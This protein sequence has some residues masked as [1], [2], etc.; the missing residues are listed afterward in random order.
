MRRLSL[1]GIIYP[2]PAWLRK[3]V[4]SELLG[5]PPSVRRRLE[6]QSSKSKTA[7]DRHED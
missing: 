1:R 3:L 5:P 7:P 6:Q 2:K 4:M